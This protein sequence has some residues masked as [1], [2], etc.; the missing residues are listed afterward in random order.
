MANKNF[1]VKFGLEVGSTVT[2]DAATGNITTSGD[3]AV[4][5]GDITTTSATAN[6][7]NTNA[8]TVNIGGG[9]TTAVVIGNA[10]G[11]IDTPS[12][13]QIIGNKSLRQGDG[14][15]SGST[16]IFRNNSGVALEGIQISNSGMTTPNTADTALVIRNYGENTPGGTSVSQGP[17]NI[18]L[19][20]TRGTPAS[21]LANNFFYT[22][23]YIGTFT[24]YGDTT[25]AGTGNGWSNDL[26]SAF[27]Q[28]STTQVFTTQDHR[29]TAQATFTA[30]QAGTTLTVTAVA[31]GT[32]VP[33]H[34]IRRSGSVS[35]SLV[36]T[37][38]ITSTA[39]GNALGGTGTYQLSGASSFTSQ[40]CTT[41][42][43]S[44]GTECSFTLLP[45][46]VNGTTL[47]AVPIAVN[48]QQI[49]YIP[50][51]G[52]GD[53]VH[54]YRTFTIQPNWNYYPVAT[55]IITEI[56]GGNT[57]NIGT[58]N[59]TTPGAT[60]TVATLG[61][62]NGLTSLATY[63]ID[64]IPSATTVTLRTN[65]VSGGAVTGLTN[66]SNLFISAQTAAQSYTG[67]RNGS[68]LILFGTR[69]GQNYTGA[70]APGSNN[71][72]DVNRTND[73]LGSILFTGFRTTGG[74][75]SQLT[76]ISGRCTEDWTSATNLGS[77]ILLTT[78]KNATSTG[79]TTQIGANA[80]V[81]RTDNF[82]VI[83]TAGTNTL[84]LDINGNLIIAGDIRING[85]DIQNGNGTTVMTMSLGT[86]PNVIFAGDIRINGN[87]INAS[88]G[89]TNITLNSNTL[90]TFAGDIRINGNDIQN[91]TGNTAITMA[92]GGNPLVT[93]AGDIKI[94][95][96]DIQ[97]SAG[98]NNI[99]L[100]NTNTFI[101]ADRVNYS[102]STAN[103]LSNLQFDPGNAQS[104]TVGGR[105]TS[106][107][108]FM[109]RNPTFTAERP[110]AAF[111]N[112]IQDPSTLVY[113]P[114]LAGESLGVLQYGGQYSTT[115][116]L[117]SNG[118]SVLF[119]GKAAENYSITANG[120][121]AT[122]DVVKIGTA[123]TSY[124]ALAVDSSNAYLRS[125]NIYFQDNN[126]VALTS[127]N[128]NY[129]RTYG[130]F[131]YAN[132]AG[133]A[134]AAQNTIYEMPLD[135]TLVNSGVTISNTSRIN[136]NVSG[137]YK[138]FMSLQSTLTVSNQP[139]QFDFWLRKN[140]VD[141]ANSKTQV[142]LLKDQK[143]VTSMHW[144]VESDGNDYW[145][146]VYVGTTANYADID[147]PT[148]AAT[149]TPYVSPVAPALLVNVIP[150]GM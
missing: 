116:T 64:T 6:I 49:R 134:I 67:D 126:S 22:L 39:A 107:A 35:Y 56:T 74:T 113:S 99:Q 149:T 140:G 55:R 3:I 21:P 62:P 100:S 45:S 128:I 43:V 51:I 91:S 68:A 44:S 111:N 87:D 93:F 72:I 31:S 14:P 34:E 38:Q 127:A 130:E 65:S 121:R 2:A 141:V 105:Q 24:N 106:F 78:V 148:I 147:F 96:N 30:S 57:L 120:G 109:R 48:Q 137:F 117:A 19:G 66:G 70:T 23:S 50:N 18:Y 88:D 123:S 61:N 102:V 139:A 28:P 90:T 82:D 143:T 36:V 114:N 12:D 92:T 144:L 125:N 146:I 118:P 27:N 131:A 15:Y 97:N 150:V 10:A 37:R 133:F 145:E 60:F 124:E 46:N 138:I 108:L 84:D 76:T 112:W 115:T 47:S 122:I 71:T 77:E 5:G 40:T 69:R 101:N 41:N 95:G 142:D 25:G 63:F 98:N 59:F 86:P 54:N 81:F 7:V 20:G 83:N 42:T 16:D 9:A 129:T 52:G 4:N 1:Q 32:I 53:E 75:T 104:G 17:G 26:Y 11:E 136:I 110:Q 29:R 8:T 94:N 79:Y 135:T 80:S 132:A 13:I 89:N 33:G 103:G 85:N 119:S 73:T 58:H